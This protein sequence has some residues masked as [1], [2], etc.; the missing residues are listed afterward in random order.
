MDE[1]TRKT[2][3]IVIAIIVLISV[4]G[5]LCVLDHVVFPIEDDYPIAPERPEG[6]LVDY[7][8]DDDALPASCLM[9][10]LL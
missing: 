3:I 10:G 2:V 6:K 8:I 4:V 1:K 7:L 5:V 9:K